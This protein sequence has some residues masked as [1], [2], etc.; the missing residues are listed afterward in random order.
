[1]KKYILLIVYTLFALNVISEKYQTINGITRPMDG[2]SMALG[3]GISGL[4]E[5]SFKNITLTYLL[6]YQLKELSTRNIESD[7]KTK[8]MNLHIRWSQTGEETFLEDVVELGASKNLSESFQLGVKAGFYHYGLITGEKGQTLLSEIECKYRP[9]EKMQISVYIFNPTGSS[10]KKKDTPVFIGQSIN[11]GGSFFPS[12]S[13]EFLLEIEKMEQENLIW[14]IGFEYGMR[15]GFFLRTG[16]SGAPF[17]PSWGIGGHLRH[18][19]CALGGNMHPTLGL[20]SCFSLS[21]N[22]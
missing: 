2:R 14:H 11:I 5:S 19:R 18:F 17:R 8:W 13:T 12:E 20:S 16:L 10:L 6:P 3:G 7:F 15:K 21:Y 4:D 9:Y 1:M 22:W